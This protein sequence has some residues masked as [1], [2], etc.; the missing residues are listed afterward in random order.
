MWQTLLCFEATHCAVCVRFVLHYW[1]GVHGEEDSG[2]GFAESTGVREEKKE[3]E[4]RGGFSCFLQCCAWLSVQQRGGGGERERERLHQPSPQGTQRTPLLLVFFSFCI[5]LE[6]SSLLCTIW[7]LEGWIS[8]LLY[9]GITLRFRE[10]LEKKKRKYWSCRRG[11]PSLLTAAL[12]SWKGGG[13]IMILGWGC[14]VGVLRSPFFGGTA[15]AFLPQSSVGRRGFGGTLSCRFR[16][17]A[18]PWGPLREERKGLLL[19]STRGSA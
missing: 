3:R 1:A 9:L 2:R 10:T 11:I 17:W 5:V 4:I 19:G 12:Q 7:A 15:G 16:G 14:S 6:S 8:P 13:D 18:Q